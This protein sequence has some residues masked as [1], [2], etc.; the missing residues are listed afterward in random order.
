MPWGCWLLGT[1]RRLRLWRWPQIT[2]R[3][4]PAH[5]MGKTKTVTQSNICVFVLE[6]SVVVLLQVTTLFSTLHVADI[7]THDTFLLVINVHFS[8]PLVNIFLPLSYFIQLALHAQLS[9]FVLLH[10]IHIILVSLVSSRSTRVSGQCVAWPSVGWGLSS[11]V[12]TSQRTQQTCWWRPSSCS[13]H[14]LLLLGN[15]QFY[16][17]I[18]CQTHQ[19]T[20]CFVTSLCSFSRS[21]Q[22]ISVSLS[23]PQVGFLRFLH[24]L[25]SF[26][27]R[28]NPLIVN[29]NNQLAGKLSHPLSL[30]DT[31]TNTPLTS[32][33]IHTERTQC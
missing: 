30:G 4:S 31:Q 22:Y 1:T 15:Y 8:Q 19:W 6:S 12:K 2:S 5:C 28:N 21:C 33:Y 32:F 7:I 25:A 14:P 11:S 27:W 24:L 26:D 10:L 9:H 23:S 18:N 20:H 17:L 13:P 16:F 3:Y 29:L